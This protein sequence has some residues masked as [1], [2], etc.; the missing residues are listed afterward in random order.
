MYYLYDKCKNNELDKKLIKNFVKFVYSLFVRKFLLCFSK[1]TFFEYKKF[2]I[3][4][5]L[6]SFLSL[7]FLSSNL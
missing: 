2:L 3:S 6:T 4:N 1:M 7:S 5:F